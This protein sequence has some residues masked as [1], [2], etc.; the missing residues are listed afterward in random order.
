VEKELDRGLEK[1]DGKIKDERT[2]KTLNK[3]LKGLL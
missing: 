3:L 1:L 2:K